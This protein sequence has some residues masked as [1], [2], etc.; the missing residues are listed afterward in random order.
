MTRR[1]PSPRTVSTARPSARPKG[2]CGLAAVAAFLAASGAYAQGFSTG[3]VFLDP[4]DSLVGGSDPRFPAP[5][6]LTIS[7]GTL[8]GQGLAIG[9]RGAT[10]S[11]TLL[12]GAVVTMSGSSSTLGTNPLN[13]ANN[14]DGTLT[15]SGGSIL[16]AGTAA[17]PSCVVQNC[18]VFIGGSAGYTG[19]LSLSGAG[20]AANLGGAFLGIGHGSVF[21]NPPST[22]DLGIPGGTA[23]GIV[24]ITDGARLNSFNTLMAGPP[25]G[26]NPT[27]AER[28]V[29]NVSISGA[30][31]L[32]N[33]DRNPLNGGSGLVVAGA[34]GA[35]ARIDI[36]SSGSLVVNHSRSSPA[37][38]STLPFVSI[39]TAGG[40]GTVSVNGGS[41]VLNGDTGVLNVGRGG[42]GTMSITGGGQISGGTP[43]GLLFT[44]I[45]R[46]GTGTLDVSGA[47]SR[48]TV[49]GVGGPNTQGLTGFG[50]TLQVGRSGPGLDGAP[51]TGFLN[52]TSGGRILVSDGAQTAPNGVNM[53]VGAGTATSGTVTLQGAESLIDVVATGTGSAA[54]VRI[55]TTN[56]GSSTGAGSG[57]FSISSGAQLSVSSPIGASVEVGTGVD[58]NGVRSQGSLDVSSGGGVTANRLTVGAGG[59]G[60]ATFNAG[61]LSLGGSGPGALP[62]TTIG[63]TMLVGIG[64]GTGTVSLTNGSTVNFSSTV[65]ATGILL[66]GSPRAAAGNGTLLMSGG[67]RITFAPGTSQSFL[68]VGAAAGGS[69]QLNVTGASRIAMS[70]DGSVVV[71]RDAL[72]GG[73]LILDGASRLDAGTF[74]GVSHDGAASTNGAGVAIV[75]GGSTLAADTIRIGAGGY[76]G[77]NGTLIGNTFVSG[78]TLN[79]GNSPGRMV[80]DGGFDFESGL[81]VLEIESDGLGGFLTD[82]LVFTRPDLVD[83]TGLDIQFAFLG[84]TN[85]E[86]FLASTLWSLDT[87]FRFNLQPGALL[88]NDVGIVGDFDALFRGSIFG[89]SSERFGIAAF[90]F[91]PAHGVTQLALVPTPATLALLGIAALAWAGSARRRRSGLA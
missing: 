46:E 59:V 33:I 2:A 88:E 87:F 45:G 55:G 51:G 89:A 27:G 73:T 7:A 18:N 91:D 71:A 58:A 23:T 60:T 77:G 79:V 83:L 62:G 67:S 10:G 44:A 29:A 81:I 34:S 28:T 14:G 1:S 37:T 49:S 4:G 6:T 26:D 63:G 32:W 53:S 54:S 65:P 47:G 57:N 16:T 48:L 56:L 61:T 64:G 90:S 3:Q 50:G 25:A 40:T 70:P 74:F 13:V 41:M 76:L 19:T 11:V 9:N 36:T 78:G 17:N 66:G 30:G 20:T 31:S 80:F 52:V 15:M 43:D 8:L 5:G 85:P 42:T 38:D 22:F 12:N 24:S 75:T 86:D 72:S 68:N 82:A 39:G 84:A 69:G 21:T 35:T